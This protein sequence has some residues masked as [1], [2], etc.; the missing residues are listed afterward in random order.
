MR[1]GD[2]KLKVNKRGKAEDADEGKI[3]YESATQ[4]WAS[5]RLEEEDR[6]KKRKQVVVTGGDGDE[7]FVKVVGRGKKKRSKRRRKVRYLYPRTLKFKRAQLDSKGE[8]LLKLCW[9]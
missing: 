3:W 9:S 8:N 5:K 4:R 6:E 1:L 2:A 7:E